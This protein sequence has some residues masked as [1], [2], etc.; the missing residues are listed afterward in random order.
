MITEHYIPV[1]KSARYF[2]LKPKTKHLA[3][4]YA[5][6]GYGQ[7][8]PYFVKQFQALADQG[9]VVVAPEGLHRFYINGYSGRVG[10]SWMTKEDRETDIKDYLNYLNV[11]HQEIQQEYRDL[12]LHLLGF[13][14][15]VATACRWIGTS[16]IDF[17][18]LILYASVFPN[19]FD[20]EVNRERLTKMKRII[21]YGD[22]DQFSPEETIEEKI[23]WL[24]KKNVEPELIRFKG[25]HEIIDDVLLDIWVKA[26]N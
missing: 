14:Q 20:F 8:G 21:A 10:A 13:S 23:N 15:G 9:V 25:G 24:K 12:P 7:L 3:L 11:F 4:V 1:N 6:H 17:Q 16:D 19:D 18:S 22:K 5:L 2:V 26:N